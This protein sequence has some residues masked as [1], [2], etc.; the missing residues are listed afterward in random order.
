MKNSIKKSIILTLVALFFLSAT[1]SIF[2]TAVAGEP[3]IKFINTFDGL[4]ENGILSVNT[5][6]AAKIT[7][8][9]QT[10][11]GTSV[12][13]IAPEISGGNKDYTLYAESLSDETNTVS[14]TITVVCKKLSIISYSPASVM[15][16]EDV[17]VQVSSNFEG[18]TT[19]SLNFGSSSGCTGIWG[20]GSVT[21]PDVTP[22]IPGGSIPVSLFA[23]KLS[24][25][26]DSVTI[27]VT[28]SST[29][30]VP[31]NVCV[32]YNHCPVDA[33]VSV[34]GGYATPSSGRTYGNAFSCIV[35]PSAQGTTVSATAS[36][37]N[38]E[39]ESLTGAA[40]TKVYPDSTGAGV[41]IE[42]SDDKDGDGD[43]SS[44]DSSSSVSSKAA[45]NIINSQIANDNPVLQ[46]FLNNIIIFPHISSSTTTYSNS[47]FAISVSGSGMSRTF[48]S[49]NRASFSISGEGGLYGSGTSVTY[50][51][52]GPGSYEWSATS[53]SGTDSGTVTISS[54]SSGP[55][56]AGSSSASASS[57]TSSSQSTSSGSTNS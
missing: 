10:R 48:S 34:T 26:S 50:T 56:S 5:N 21:A 54:G 37:T 7:F 29:T 30:D 19:S 18:G 11:F 6:I 13:F 52:P 22:E 41:T 51:Y 1:G 39:G 46:S 55:D 23:S 53:S 43:D 20:S 28:D 3:P 2:T 25:D 8:A 14:K 27:T 24:H 4:W 16:F 49:V 35:K 42:L 15:E 40:S 57:S 31:F 12:T 47:Y 33:S 36:Y 44:V 45:T 17:S 38:E 9:G 32:N